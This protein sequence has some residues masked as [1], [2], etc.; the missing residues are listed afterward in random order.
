VA[1]PKKPKPRQRKRTK[2]QRVEDTKKV[3]KAGDKGPREGGRYD[4]VQRDIEIYRA[5]LR[6]ISDYDLA[7]TYALTVPTVREI[8]KGVRAEGPRLT[9]ANPLDVIEAMTAQIDAGISELAALAAREKGTARVNA[10]TARIRALFDKAKFLQSVGVL[11]SEA[12]EVR[13][14]INILD[15]AERLTD[16]LERHDL[17]TDDVAK[18]IND[19]FDEALQ[20]T[21]REVT[22]ALALEAVGES[23]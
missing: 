20:G 12:Q 3:A 10:V 9:R 15:L 22:P 21:A 8:I 5:H 1:E 4:Q 17:L 13:V 7:A 18:S 11:P 19:E 16:I 2:A 6:G 14:Q 23:G